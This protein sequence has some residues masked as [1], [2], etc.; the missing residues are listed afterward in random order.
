MSFVY[1]LWIR[2][3]WVISLN[4]A[5]FVPSSTQFELN[6]GNDFSSYIVLWRSSPS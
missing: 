2:V 5:Y 4:L 6:V 1:K 3:T